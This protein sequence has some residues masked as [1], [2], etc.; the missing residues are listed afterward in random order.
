MSTTFPQSDELLTPREAVELSGVPL[1]MVKKAISQR[2]VAGRRRGGRVFLTAD[3]LSGLGILARTKVPLPVEKKRRVVAWAG[4][5]IQAGEELELDEVLVVKAD[6]AALALVE[7]ARRYVRL[8]NELIVSDPEV[9]GGEPVIRGSRVPVRGLAR[10]IEA[11]E[12]AEVLREDY[13]HLPEAAFEIAPVWAR[14]NP[15]TGRPPK[16]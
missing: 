14:A 7:H 16:A 2:V 5:G 15:R 10:Q 8:R 13:P 9:A 12:S 4:Q 11:G 6:P 3:V 1:N